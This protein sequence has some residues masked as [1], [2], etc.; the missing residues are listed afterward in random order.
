M[1]AWL[2]VGYL[3]RYG[4]RRASLLESTSPSSHIG[5]RP[6][7]ERSRDCDTHRVSVGKK[8]GG[9]SSTCRR[10]V[11]P[12]FDARKPAGAGVQPGANRFRVAVDGR[13]EAGFAF[14]NRDADAGFERVQ[15]SVQ[16]GFQIPEILLG[17]GFVRH[18]PLPYEAVKQFWGHACRAAEVV[19]TL[20]PARSV[21]EL[22]HSFLRVA[23]RCW[24]PF[25]ASAPR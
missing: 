19:G 12:L 13:Q 4:L 3:P 10:Q 2:P 22:F 11:E 15:F 1:K 24:G 23:P 14:L 8:A 18:G 5:I 16:P 25:S 21:P 20:Q 7:T 9:T 17:G 6:T